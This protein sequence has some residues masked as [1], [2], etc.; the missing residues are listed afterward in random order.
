[1]EISQ[2]DPLRLRPHGLS[3]DELK[4]LAEYLERLLEDADASLD[5][6]RDAQGKGGFAHQVDP[7][8]GPIKT[9]KAST[10]TCVTYL[11]AAGKLTGKK[12][13]NQYELRKHLIEDEWDSAELGENN[14]FTVSFLLEATHALGGFDDL[15]EQPQQIVNEKIDLLNQLLIE[16]NGGLRIPPYSATAFLTYKA[17][18]ALNRWKRLS[19]DARKQAREWT[20]EKLYEE[21][22]LIAAGTPDADYLELAYAALTASETAALDQMTPHKRRVLRHAVDQFFAGQRED[23]SWPRSRPLFLYPKV[24]NAYCYDYELLVPLL[25]DP[26]MGQ[27]VAPHLDSLRR[28]AWALDARKVPLVRADAQ[29]ETGKPKAD[30]KRAWGWSSEHHGRQFSAESWP[31]AS[32]FHFCFELQR[33]VAAAVRRDL[34]EYVDAT[35]EEPLARAPEGEPLEGLMDSE[36]EYEPGKTQSFKD[37]FVKNFLAPLI[38]ERDAVRDGRSFGKKT[39]VSAILYGPP[40]TSKTRLARMISDALGW[41]LLPLD[42]SHFTRRGLD[43][44]HAE[45]DALFGRLQRCDQVLVLLDEIDELVREREASGEATSRFLTTA[46]LPKLAELHGRRK[47]VYLVATNHLEKFDAAIS[48]PGRFDVIVPLMPPTVEAKLADENFSALADARASLENAGGVA[49]SLGEYDE[50]VGDLTYDEAE[51]LAQ[52]LMGGGDADRITELAR[53]AEKGATLNKPVVEPE[54]GTVDT[55]EDPPAAGITAAGEEP[56]GEEDAGTPD[57][58]GGGV[59]ARDTASGA[60]AGGETWKARIERPGADE[61][62]EAEIERHKTSPG[63]E[64]WKARIR[65]QRKKIRGLGL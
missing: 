4:N 58:S 50:I 23:G 1:M 45:A 18:H 13:N 14:P 6:Y 30:E 51:E 55:E 29:T 46:M 24:G 43:N 53:R 3:F 11:R 7:D 44:I 22:M 49:V 25:A 52:K 36:V 19:D 28:A 31:T 9:S 59:K 39:K 16:N 32:V 35:Y 17:V 42:P 27:F 21:S 60:S 40:G 56:K 5:Y 33:V 2:A 65:S 41:P 37:L 61:A 20:W 12:W 57:S 62:W 26:Q 48:R 10:A 15:E 63:G 64:T 54:T 47:V 34:F 8:V 38:A